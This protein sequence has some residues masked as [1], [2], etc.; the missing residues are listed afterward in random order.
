MSVVENYSLDLGYGKVQYLINEE[1][2]GTIRAN[3]FITISPCQ[4]VDPFPKELMEE[5]R[6]ELKEWFVENDVKCIMEFTENWPNII[7]GLENIQDCRLFRL[8]FEDKYEFFRV[9]E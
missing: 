9:V 3:I 7:I 1:S 2:P 6:E 8:V 5:T 4:E